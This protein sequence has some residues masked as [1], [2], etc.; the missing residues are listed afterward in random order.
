MPL[1]LNVGVS[2][3][4]G[5]PAYSSIG[6]SC[7]LEAVLAHYPH[8]EREFRFDHDYP[9]IPPPQGPTMSHPGDPAIRLDRTA[10]PPHAGGPHA[11]RPAR[12]DR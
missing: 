9:P 12:V 3:K 11:L 7:N 10:R 4:L 6:A 5:L 8:R 1:R 2:R